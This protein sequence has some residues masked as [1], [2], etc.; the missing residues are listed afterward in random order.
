MFYGYHRVFGFPELINI[1][2]YFC[3]AGIVGQAHFL[4]KPDGCLSI[5]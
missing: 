5:S 2:V 1:P 4:L 3:G